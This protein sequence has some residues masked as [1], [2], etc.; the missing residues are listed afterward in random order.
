MSDNESPAQDL[1]VPELTP[2]KR[3]RVRQLLEELHTICGDQLVYHVMLHGVDTTAGV[4]NANR[5]AYPLSHRFLVA[6]GLFQRLL[7]V[8]DMDTVT[9]G[10]KEHNLV[11]LFD[12]A[13]AYACHVS[14]LLALT[15]E[16]L[17]GRGGGVK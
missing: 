13:D 17:T 11:V 8:V 5:V 15:I 10:H 4:T 14:Q 3:D 6:A 1:T 9:V 2:E 12:D 7:H 16:E